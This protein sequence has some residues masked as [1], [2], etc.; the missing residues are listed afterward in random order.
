MERPFPDSLC[1]RCAR[2][3]H[4]ETRRGSV[5]LQCTHPDLPKYSPQPVERC[6]GFAP[7]N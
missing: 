7:A 6:P 3:R 2:L 5:F 4:V 1:H